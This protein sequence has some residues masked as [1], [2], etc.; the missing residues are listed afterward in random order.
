MKIVA[1]A[2]RNWGIKVTNTLIELFPD[3]SIKVV[4]SPEQFSE[5]IQPGLPDAILAI[6]WSWKFQHSIVKGT[7]VVGIHP[8]DLPKFAGGS[9]IQNQILAGITQTMNTLFRLT[10]DI[11]A[12]PILGKLPLSLD[13]HIEDIFERLTQTSII[14]LADFIR[15]FP[16]VKAEPQAPSV[17][18]RRLKPE[19]S[20]LKDYHQMTAKNLYDSIRCREDPY[21]NAYIEDATGRLI[22]KRVEFIRRG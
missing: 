18:M 5:A 12:G 21:P 20:H 22:F 15:A 14:L 17:P 16:D 1:C 19:S 13:G 11:D 2:Y 9:P 10:P 4:Q 8:S 7:W 3:H 6:G